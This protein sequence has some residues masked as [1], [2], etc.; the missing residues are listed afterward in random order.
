MSEAVFINIGSNLRPGTVWHSDEK[1]NFN[2]GTPSDVQNTQLMKT[3]K[4]FPA[5]K[6]ST[7]VYT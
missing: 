2:K 1:G 3:K 4:R 6:E 5:S 7:D